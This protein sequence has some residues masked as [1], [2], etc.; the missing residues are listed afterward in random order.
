VRRAPCAQMSNTLFGE[1]DPNVGV[2]NAK[3]LIPD[4]RC[5]FLG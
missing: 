5:L 4:M 3:S 1:P 2:A